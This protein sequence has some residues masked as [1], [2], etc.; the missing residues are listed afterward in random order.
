MLVLTAGLFLHSLAVS[1][2]PT[3]ASASAQDRGDDSKLELVAAVKHARF[4][5]GDRDTYSA[6]LLLS[7]RYINSGKRAAILYRSQHPIEIT[8]AT[9]AQNLPSLHNNRYETTL[10]Y[11]QFIE[12]PSAPD[13]PRPDPRKFKVIAPGSSF[14]LTG[15]VAIPVRFKLSPAISGTIGP[16][17]HVMTAEVSNWPF[18]FKGIDRLRTKW[19]GIGNLEYNEIG[20]NPFSFVIPSDP[21]LEDCS[22]NEK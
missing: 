12:P 9:I 14:E 18:S 13:T 6:H 20:T 3:R 16:G 2:H 11:D 10:R 21:H 7:L 19:S 8:R 22:V 1:S 17:R 15:M 4:C 5:E